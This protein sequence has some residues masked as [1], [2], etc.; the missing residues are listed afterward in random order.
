MTKKQLQKEWE[1]IIKEVHDKPK[2]RT[3]YPKQVVL[4]RELLLFA[5]VFLAKI[6]NKDNILFNSEVYQKVM[7]EYYRQKLCLKI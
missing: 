2:C 6:E 7:A 3:P 1:K 4:V 5:E